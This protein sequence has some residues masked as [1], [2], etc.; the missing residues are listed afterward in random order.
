MQIDVSSLVRNEGFDPW[1]LCNSRA[2]LGDDAGRTTWRASVAL[3]QQTAPAPLDTEEKREAFRDFVR[4]S[5]G[6]LKR[7]S[8]LGRMTS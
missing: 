5:G 2:N 3:A 6:G 1:Y 8:T 4:D 7:R